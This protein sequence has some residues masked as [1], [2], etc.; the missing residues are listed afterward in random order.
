[1]CKF[2]CLIMGEVGKI[3]LS[4]VVPHE[5]VCSAQSESHHGKLLKDGCACGTRVEHGIRNARRVALT[6]L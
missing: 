6:D 1:M 2:G 3:R 4:W 5:W